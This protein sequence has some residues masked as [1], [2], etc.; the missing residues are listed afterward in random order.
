MRAIQRLRQ[1]AAI[2]KWKPVYERACRNGETLQQVADRYGLTRERIRQV[3]A[4]FTKR[5]DHRKAGRHLAVVQAEAARKAARITTYKCS[6]CLE[7]F[8]AP[9]NKKRDSAKLVYCSDEHKYLLRTARYRLFP[10]DR[11]KHYESMA[12]RRRAIRDMTRKIPFRH[13]PGSG[14]KPNEHSEAARCERIVRKMWAKKN[15]P[16]QS[17]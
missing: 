10:E 3:F 14:N 6:T 8:Q 4:P 12:R 5:K 11:A 16:A 15:E 13:S 7:P 2:A 17:R 1:R 9:R